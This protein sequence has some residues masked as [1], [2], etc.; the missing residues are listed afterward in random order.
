LDA[1]SPLEIF[2]RLLVGSEG[3]LGFVAEAVFDTVPLGR[4]ATIA[5]ALF[6]DLDAAAGA[7]G[8]LVAAR[9]AATELMGAPTLIAAAYNM[10]GTPERWKELPPTSAAVLVEFRAEDPELLDEPERDA[11]E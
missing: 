4:H 9:A 11:L 5:L 1:D 6:E 3:T 10:P 8:P 7:G 2:R